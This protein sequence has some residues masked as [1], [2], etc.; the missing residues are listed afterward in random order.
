[1][2]IQ[3]LTES[4]AAFPGGL[5]IVA[6]VPLMHHHATFTIGGVAREVEDY[7]LTISN[8]LA[9]DR[10][11]NSKSRTQMPETDRVVGV[12]ATLPF[13]SVEVAAFYDK[14]VT[15]LVFIADYLTGVGAQQLTFT[16][17]AVQIPVRGPGVGAR[18]EILYPIE[19]H[20]RTVGA[21]MD[22]EVVAL[23]KT[24]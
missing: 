16:C 11:F 4:I 18:T 14:G 3:G 21:T 10:Y 7:S 15:P 5:S 24:A 20:C 13:S 6:G 19:M 8:A 2:D 1:M 22:S 12:T 17:P 23:I 9:L